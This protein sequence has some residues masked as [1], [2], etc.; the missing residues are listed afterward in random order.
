MGY[1]RT[2]GENVGM[3]IGGLVDNKHPHYPNHQYRQELF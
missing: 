2:I 3:G 1:N